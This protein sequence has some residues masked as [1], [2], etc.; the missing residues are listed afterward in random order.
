M[1]TKNKLK[2]LIYIQE[3]KPCNEQTVKGLFRSIVEPILENNSQGVVLCR[4]EEKSKNDFNGI[5][6]RLEYSNAK[7]YDFSNNPISDK[8]EN[9]LKARVWD[10]TEFIYIL[11]ERFGAVLIFDYEE[12]EIKNFAHF[13]LM[14]NS[15]NL[16]EAFD[17]ISA[18][19]TVDLKKYQEEFHPDRRDN[20]ILNCSIRK[21][22]ESLNETNQE[23]LISELEKENIQDNLNLSSHSEFISK[24]SN[25]VAHEIRNQLSICNLYSSIIQKQLSKI[26]FDNEDT[27]NS[28]T[29]ALEYIQKSLKISGNLLL[30]IKSLKNNDI[31]EYDV[32]NLIE[33]AIELARAYANGKDIKIKSAITETVGVLVDE[34]KFLTVL[35]NL[36]KNSVESI[37]KKGEIIIKMQVEAENVKII[38]S[39]NGS[40]ISKDV[41][42]RIFEEGFTTKTSGAGLGLFICKKTL[43]EQFSQLKLIK[44]DEV[45]TEFEITVLRGER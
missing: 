21:I 6:K 38:I 20:D 13:Y 39:N 19:A 22:V 16:S 11:A 30:D 45:S 42:A 32:K 10:K 27:A 23:I 1:Y 17:V 9:V 26:K 44:S 36:I 7:L 28:V 25:Y 33:T 12:S 31:K 14:H 40:P 2:D 29:N 24:K 37:E 4:L 3:N 5:L 15:K 35:I 18:N 8:I 41:Q 43:E 34:N